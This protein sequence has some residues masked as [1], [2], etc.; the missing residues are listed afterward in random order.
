MTHG[1][2]TMLLYKFVAFSQLEIFAQH[3]GYQLIKASEFTAPMVDQFHDETRIKS[4]FIFF[5]PPPFQQTFKD[6]LLW[7]SINEILGSMLLTHG[8]NK[9]LTNC[10][11]N[12]KVAD[13]TKYPSRFTKINEQLKLPSAH[14]HIFQSTTGSPI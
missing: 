9:T 14:T 7:Y 8:D 5:Y 1:V 2:I 11:V 6:K 13:F 10:Q 3:L 4:H 12:F